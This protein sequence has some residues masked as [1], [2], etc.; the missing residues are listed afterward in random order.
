MIIMIIYDHVV[1][2]DSMY[3]FY[4]IDDFILLVHSCILFLVRILDRRYKT[5][6]NML[7]DEMSG[8]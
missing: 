3:I 8:K 6:N 7:Q 1:L 2:L 4:H 5:Q